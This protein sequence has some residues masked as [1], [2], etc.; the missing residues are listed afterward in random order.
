MK[1]Y[2]VGPVYDW[3]FVLGAPV[4]ALVAG[5]RRADEA[6]LTEAAGEPLGRADAEFVREATGFAIGGVPPLGH[7]LVPLVDESLLRFEVV[8]AAA[9]TPHHVFGIDPRTLVAVTR[10]DVMRLS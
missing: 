3:V 4:L 8:W 2:I 10:G 6:L 7:D 5:D 9:G 1:R